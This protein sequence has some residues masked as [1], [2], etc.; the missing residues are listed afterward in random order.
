MAEIQDILKIEGVGA[1]GG[2]ILPKYVMLDPDLTLEAKCIYTYFASLAG[3]GTTVFPGRDTIVEYL[4]INKDTFYKH[5]KMLIVQNYV[6]TKQE[7][8]SNGFKK[9]IYT[10]V[11]NPKKFESLSSTIDKSTYSRIR[12]GGL[13][14]AGYGWMPYMVMTDYRLN[15]KAKGI[16][17]YFCVW[18]GSGNSAFPSKDD[19]L[20]HL[21]ISHNTYQRYYKQLIDLNYITVV[22]R[23]D[24]GRMAVNDYYLNDNPDVD[25]LPGTKISDTGKSPDTKI[26]DTGK[27]PDTKISDTGNL[28][29]TKISDTLNIEKMND[30][31]QDIVKTSPGTKFSDTGEVSPHTNF[32]DTEI[33]DININS[34]LTINTLLTSSSS[35]NVFNMSA[36]ELVDYIK[37]A[38]ALD[39]LFTEEE[40]ISKFLEI[41]K[42]FMTTLCELCYINNMQYSGLSISSL[43]IIEKLKNIISKDYFEDFCRRVL[44]DYY[45]AQSTRHIK[46]IIRYM[47]AC[48]YN[49]MLQGDGVKQKKGLPIKQHEKKNDFQN[50]PQREYDYDALILAGINKG[51]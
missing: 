30:I 33:S 34:T 13:K 27:S 49:V 15:I 17:A 5:F 48:I 7:N 21:G 29:S 1:K 16:Y 42:I 6:T 39:Q 25:C 40:E 8:S 38:G 51:I 36:N 47:Q 4:G 3:M 22:Q 28:P 19:I 45:S 35:S 10:L 50:F 24:S 46:N 14:S 41:N 2:G 43:E 37:K 26:S 20:R 12:F 11:S 9:N 32:S 23:R 31:A 44:S 18:T